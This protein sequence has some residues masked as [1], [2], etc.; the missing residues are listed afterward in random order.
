MF[1]RK[2]FISEGNRFGRLTVL[3]LYRIKKSRGSELM[4]E[5]KCDCGA[6]CIATVTTLAR[7]TKKSCG[8]LQRESVSSLSLKHG[9]VGTRLYREWKAMRSRCYYKKHQ[10]FSDYGGRGIEVCEEWRTKFE[11]FRDWAIVNGY[12]D[13]LSID[14]IDPN[15]NY[16]PENC[17]WVT[18]KKQ[19]S[20]KRNSIRVEYENHSVSLYELSEI[21]GIKYSTLYARYKRGE[22]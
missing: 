21:T 13:N 9:G 12:A 16:C 17:R 15:G 18:Q 6:T 4:A 5:C 7:G 19:A 10:Y 1:Q 22:L 11:P 3:R 8:C 20:N 14:R 2:Y